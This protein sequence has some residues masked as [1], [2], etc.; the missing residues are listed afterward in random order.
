MKVDIKKLMKHPSRAFE[1]L[2]AIDFTDDQDIDAC[3]EEVMMIGEEALIS[4]NQDVNP[5]SLLWTNLTYATIL[6][7]NIFLFPLIPILQKYRSKRGRTLER[8]I[9]IFH[10]HISFT[11]IFIY[12][13]IP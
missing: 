5:I 10:H 7:C 2:G 6:S 9:L 1:D 4:P 11:V 12:H 8:S 3:V 13:L